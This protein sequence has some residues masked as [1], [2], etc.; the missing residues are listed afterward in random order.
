MLS[1]LCRMYF[2]AAQSYFYNTAKKKL[3]R[4]AEPTFAFTTS[5]QWPFLQAQ[6]SRTRRWSN[7]AKLAEFT[8]LPQDLRQ[9]WIELCELSASYTWWAGFYLGSK[10]WLPKHLLTEGV[11]P[12][13]DNRGSN[14]VFTPIKVCSGRSSQWSARCVVS[15]RSLAQ[16]DGK[17]SHLFCLWHAKF[18]DHFCLR[19]RREQTV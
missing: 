12:Q 6:R 18:A 15:R 2:F 7:Q 1:I 5:V 19:V 11:R 16:V 9:F 8:W 3:I 4:S 10:K 13:G 17:T 14:D